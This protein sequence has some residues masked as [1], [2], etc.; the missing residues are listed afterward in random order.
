MLF[1]NNYKLFFTF[2]S[3]LFSFILP[4]GRF[5]A[6]TFPTASTM[7]FRRDTDKVDRAS[8]GNSEDQSCSLFD[9]KLQLFFDDL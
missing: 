5:S 6:M 3:I 1:F 7:E 2:L 9:K 4:V 8:Q